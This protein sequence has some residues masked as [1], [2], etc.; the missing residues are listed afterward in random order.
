MV[1]KWMR[2]A[3]LETRKINLNFDDNR[4][5]KGKTVG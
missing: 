1:V 4:A 3:S 2:L 5:P